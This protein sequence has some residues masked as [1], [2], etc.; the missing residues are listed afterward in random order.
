MELLEV[1]QDWEWVPYEAPLV[2][3]TLPELH[4]PAMAWR[5]VTNKVSSGVLWQVTEW[6]FGIW[7]PR[8]SRSKSPARSAEQSDEPF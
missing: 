3:E 5:R 8:E 2:D 7:P 4:R 6:H 1:L